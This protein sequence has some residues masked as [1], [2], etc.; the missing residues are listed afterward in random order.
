M[1]HKIAGVLVEAELLVD[2]AHRRLVRVHLLPGLG[3][4]VVEL[5]HEDQEV[6]EAPLFEKTHQVGGQSLAFVGWNFRDFSGLAHDVATLDGL[7]LQVTSHPSVDQQ[8]DKL[9]KIITFSLINPA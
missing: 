6:S 3:I 4:V 9:K 7:E 2:L 5:L 8:L 1:S